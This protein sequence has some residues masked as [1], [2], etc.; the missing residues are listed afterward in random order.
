RQLLVN[1]SHTRRWLKAFGAARRRVDHHMWHQLESRA[2]PIHLNMGWSGNQNAWYN[3][4]N[5][6]DTYWVFDT[7]SSVVFNV[8]P[9]GTGDLLTG[10]VLDN[11]GNP[12]SGAVITAKKNQT[13][14]G[15]A[16]S[17]VNGIYSI[18]IS[19]SKEWNYTVTATYAG[20]SSSLSISLTPSASTRLEYPNTYYPGTGVVGNSWGNDFTF[21]APSTPTSLSATD[22]T[23][24]DYVTVT[25][26]AATYATS[27]ELWRGTESS[28][29]YAVY[30][31]SN[32]TAT[33]Y[34]D[35]TATP[36]VMYYYWVKAVNAVGTSAFSTT[37][38]DGYR[39]FSPL[40]ETSTTP[41]PVPYTWLDDYGL[42]IGEDYEAAGYADSDGDGYVAWEEYVAGT[43][44]TNIVSRFL[45]NI[46]MVNGLLTI[47][48]MPDLGGER[49]YTIFG[50][51]NLVDS[52]W[53]TPTN[54]STRF[55]RIGIDMN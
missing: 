42:V 10:R 32:I 3:L 34:Q 6:D 14:V 46:T 37:G 31:A 44:P 28:S 40:D 39:A 36:G 4:P 17:G 12:V 43:V 13:T 7:I 38:D 50:K 51:T 16:T 24:T 35:V 41:V 45:S 27:Y 9:S 20:L 26:S 48:W 53:M 47:E 21:N 49:T 18:K 11:S 29:T 23:S 2:Y 22:G 30:L 33:A 19:S 5:I 55:F 1:R 54:A 8:F 25:W 15:T 52:A